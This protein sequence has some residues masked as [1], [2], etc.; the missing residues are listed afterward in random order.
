M[1]AMAKGRRKLTNDEVDILVEFF[2]LLA[3]IKIENNR[4]NDE[5]K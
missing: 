4:S 3:E 2:T 5:Q 1:E